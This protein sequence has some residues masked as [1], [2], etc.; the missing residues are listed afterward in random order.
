MVSTKHLPKFYRES[1]IVFLPT[2]YREGLPL[3]LL[4][5]ASTGRALVATDVPGCREVVS[6]QVNGFLVPPKNVLELTNAL[7]K[8]LLD[9]ELR[10]K[11]GEAGSLIVKEEFSSQ[12]VQ[13]RLSNV[14]ES[15]L[16]DS[17]SYN[18]LV[19]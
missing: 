9:P 16:N 1:D 2:T 8:L 3:T 14:Y 11:F 13:T 10:R 5:A 15:L 7:R 19:P 6:D 12:I 18:V 17:V 4:E